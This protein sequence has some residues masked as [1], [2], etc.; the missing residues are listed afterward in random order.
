MEWIGTRWLETVGTK[1]S[2]PQTRR[3]SRRKFGVSWLSLKLAIRASDMLECETS[4]LATPSMRP[5]G[6]SKRTGVNAGCFRMS[7]KEALHILRGY[8]LE[9]CCSAT[10]SGKFDLRMISLFRSE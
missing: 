1:F 5:C 3:H 8:G 6:A 10:V 7:T 9:I 4:R 2:R